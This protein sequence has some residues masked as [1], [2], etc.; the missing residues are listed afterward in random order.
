M[1]CT[2]PSHFV[3]PECVKSV[4]TDYYLGPFGK[5]RHTGGI[6]WEGSQDLLQTITTS[7]E[8]VVC[9][10]PCLRTPIWVCALEGG[11]N[12]E[13]PDKV[14]LSPATPLGSLCDAL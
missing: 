5:I 7:R 10:S 6:I 13:V 1:Y 12:W 2:I 14:L 9:L 4:H 11:V 3:P 8:F